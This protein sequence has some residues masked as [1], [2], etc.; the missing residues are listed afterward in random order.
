VEIINEYEENDKYEAGNAASFI[1]DKGVFGVTSQ[2]RA[3]I[4]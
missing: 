2:K 3:C 1:L 4:F